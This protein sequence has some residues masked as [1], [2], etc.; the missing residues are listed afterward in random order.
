MELLD[1]Q[2]T[3]EHGLMATKYQPAVTLSMLSADDILIG[4]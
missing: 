3:Q 1:A 2:S 4:W